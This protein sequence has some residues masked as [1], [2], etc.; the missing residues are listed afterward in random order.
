MLVMRNRDQMNV[1]RH[2]A[3]SEDGDSARM[4]ESRKYEAGDTWHA[5]KDWPPT[6]KVRKKKRDL[7]SLSPLFHCSKSRNVHLDEDLK[8]CQPPL[9]NERA[10][11]FFANFKLESFAFQ[12]Q[13]GCIRIYD[14][15][16]AL[17]GPSFAD[18]WLY[19]QTMDEIEQ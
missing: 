3:V 5:Y 1:I 13:V 18:A 15:K 8:K 16:E 4:R 10:M 19:S 7:R 2:Q 14:G 12:G 9:T 17:S 6:E 11:R